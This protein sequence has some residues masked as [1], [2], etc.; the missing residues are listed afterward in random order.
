M[1]P[2]RPVHE[3]I[4]CIDVEIVSDSAL[5]MVTVSVDEPAADVHSETVGCEEP[6]LLMATTAKMWVPSTRR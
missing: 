3:V 5:E 6:L 2:S 1:I 4:T